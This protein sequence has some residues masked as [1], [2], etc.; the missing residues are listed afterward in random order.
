MR[1]REITETFLTTPR[2]V[3]MQV[4]RNPVPA[5]LVRML[6]RTFDRHLRGLVIGNDMHWWDANDAIHGEV[7]KLLGVEDYVNDRL[8]LARPRYSPD[9]ARFH[10]DQEAWPPERVLANPAFSKMARCPEVLFYAGSAG[11]VPGPEWMTLLVE[12]REGFAPP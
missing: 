9:E 10:Y 8:E 1:W 12:T 6:D 7:A 11:W 4:V 3:R 5:L 2:G